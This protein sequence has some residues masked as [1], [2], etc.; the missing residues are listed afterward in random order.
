[1]SLAEWL[2]H[3]ADNV[4]VATVLGPIPASDT[5][6]FEEATDE[7]V[8]N[9]VLKKYFTKSPFQKLYMRMLCFKSRLNPI[10]HNKCLYFPIREILFA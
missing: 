4:K 5:V 2:V 8:L 9:K 3:L 10:V 6:E 1:M 7:A